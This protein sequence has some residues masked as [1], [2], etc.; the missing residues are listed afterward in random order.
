[1]TKSTVISLV[2]VAVIA[3][4]G[5]R[6]KVEA[7][8]QEPKADVVQNKVPKE[9]VAEM[10]ANFAKV[11]FETDKAEINEASKAALGENA[12]IMQKYPQI[13]VEVQGHADE[14]GTTDYN[15]A[16]G[17][18]RAKAVQGQLRMMGVA[19]ARVVTVSFG[20]EKPASSGSNET[21]WSQNRRAE[22]RILTGPENV[23]G[24]TE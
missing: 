7:P 15:V 18:K 19:N 17:E 24:T 2:A 9:V 4:A 3:T 1:M 5:C 22:F 21:A 8:A 14:R 12:K 11:H 6:K 13:T 16:L 10:A 20:E 23:K